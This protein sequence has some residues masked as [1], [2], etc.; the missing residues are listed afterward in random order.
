VLLAFTFPVMGIVNT[1]ATVAGLP[2]LFVYIFVVW[3]L[4]TLLMVL[5]AKYRLR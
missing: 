2:V 5:I 3:T 1:R 4:F